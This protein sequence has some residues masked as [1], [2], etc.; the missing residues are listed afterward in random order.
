MSSV[1]TQ[2]RTGRRATWAAQDDHLFESSQGHIPRARG[3]A[4]PRSARVP[5][6][7]ASRWRIIGHR[8]HHVHVSA[9]PPPLLVW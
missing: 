2:A 5:P 3:T 6:C 4:E 9:R 8:P 1:A 7:G